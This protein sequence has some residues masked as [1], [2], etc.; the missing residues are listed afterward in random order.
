MSFQYPPRTP[1]AHAR[2]W[3]TAAE[4]AV[5]RE[6]QN[7]HLVHLHSRIAA[8]EE[9]EAEMEVENTTRPTAPNADQDN[10]AGG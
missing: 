10:T 1:F 8:D 4:I 7:I 2:S 9:E 5:D 6:R 3:S